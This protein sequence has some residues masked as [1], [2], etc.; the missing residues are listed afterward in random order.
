MYRSPVNL[1]FSGTV[2]SSCITDGSGQFI[3]REK[4]AVTIDGASEWVRD[5]LKK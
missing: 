5:V 1:H 3:L 4:E 2:Y